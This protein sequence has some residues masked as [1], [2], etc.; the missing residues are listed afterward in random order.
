MPKLEIDAPDGKTLEVDV[1]E[2]TDPSKYDGI[3]NDVIADYTKGSST[4]TETPGALKSAALGAMSGIPGAE[5][6]VSGVQAIDPKTTFEQAHQ[7]LED[8]K[9]KAWE[10]H[11]VAYGTG[12]T[13][14]MAGTALAAPTGIPAA[15]GLGAA[16]GLD[17]ANKPSEF[18]ESAGKGAATGFAL[19]KIG[20]K[21][22]SPAL[23]SLSNAAPQLA[24]K[25][26]AALGNK[27]T[28]ED[29]ERYLANPE[30]VNAAGTVEDVG[31]KL[32]GLTDDVTKASG[33]L[34]NMARGELNPSNT[35]DAKSLKDAAME[36]VQKYYVDGNVATKADQT[37][38]NTI[39]DQYNKLT[40]IA[41]TNGGNLP[42]TTLRQMIDRIQSATKDST[43]GNP[44]AGASQQALKEFGGKLND[45]LR[46][47]NPDYAEQMAPSAEAAK[48]SSNLQNQ[49][50]LDN[51]ETTDSTLS[52]V[53]NLLKP[54]KP[55]G[56]DLAGQLQNLTGTDI[57]GALKNA[58]TNE[59]LS[60]GGA[61][62]ATK[63]LM[64]TL[65]FGVGKMTGI[66]Y[67]GIAGAASGRF[68]A[69]AVNGGNIAKSIMDMYLQGSEGFSNS[70][71]K[72]IMAKFG[73]VLINAAKQGGNQL[74]ATHFVLAT[75]NPEYQQ[76][77]DHV[78]NNQSSDDQLNTGVR[79]QE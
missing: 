41:E 33:Q 73:P 48:L 19:G 12:K 29:I 24:K 53:N 70:A 37:A 79:N 36:A 15:V 62:E 49:F 61:G 47:T 17:V 46:K 57:M 75:S 68:G 5:T 2:G 65:G 20:E 56:Q 42:E 25:V 8:A 45:L 39:I 72:P 35:L 10:E 30:A 3:V 60:T 43:Y 23:E 21:I 78:Q 28:T 71:L 26:L 9:N 52:K 7:G 66:P 1:P 38:V 44:E 4:P 51:G 32:A 34:S 11:P 14:G 76:L 67:G 59:N 40:D 77:A 6:L 50:K 54:G 64:A 27:A 22:I 63:A 69:N 58:K 18:L 16:A 31:N 74:A 55:E 13:V